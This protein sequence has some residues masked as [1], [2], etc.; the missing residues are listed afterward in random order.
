[1]ASTH[2]R[3]SV[4][5]SYAGGGVG[6]QSCCGQPRGRDRVAQDDVVEVGTAEVR[7]SERLA[8]DAHLTVVV[9]AQDDR[10]E[11]AAT[12]V[13]DGERVPGLERR[14]GLVVPRRGL[15]LADQLHL[16][17]DLARKGCC[18]ETGTVSAPRHRN[19]DA[20]ALRLSA[21]ALG[22]RVDDP[23]DHARIQ[24]F[25]CEAL[26][27]RDDRNVIAHSTLEFAD[28]PLGL[29]ESAPFG[30]FAEQQLSVGGE[31]RARRTVGAAPK[32]ERCGDDRSVGRRARRG[33][34][35][36]ARP[37]IDGKK[38]R[39]RCHVKFPQETDLLHPRVMSTTAGAAW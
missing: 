22:H 12:Q 33:S 30:G 18:D 13:V 39:H 35:C 28:E 6:R 19:R 9:L 26:V 7:D 15:G 11:G 14:G 27:A 38:I 20:D 32:A 10:V 23:R 1:M 36:P 3:R 31:D 25:G 17:G 5:E 4:D 37:H 2:S 24:L 34:G 8:D 21:L 29:R 16:A